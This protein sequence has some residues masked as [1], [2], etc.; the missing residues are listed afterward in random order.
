M[1]LRIRRAGMRL[2][3]SC[4]RAGSRVPVRLLSFVSEVWFWEV[5]RSWIKEGFCAR[6]SSVRRSKDIEHNKEGLVRAL[7]VTN[8]RGNHCGNARLGRTWAHGEQQYYFAFRQRNAL[9]GGVDGGRARH[10]LTACP[11]GCSSPPPPLPCASTACT[12]LSDLPHPIT[13]V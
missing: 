2:G 7:V 5:E 6:R 4:W 13:I 11:S 12:L 10:R 1:T 3:D 8:A 9:C